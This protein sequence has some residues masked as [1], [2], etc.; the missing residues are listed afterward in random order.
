MLR[1]PRLSRAPLLFGIGLLSLSDA[2]GA[3]QV[4]PS[5]IEQL[6]RTLALEDGRTSGSG[7]LDRILRGP[8]KGLRRRAALAAGRIG[9]RE[10]LPALLEMLNDGEPELRQMAAFSLGLIGDSAGV[11]RL[12]AALADSDPR[13]RSR[14]AEALGRIGNSRAAAPIVEYIRRVTPLTPA[15]LVVRGDDPTN[16][17]DPWTEVRLGLLALPGL[18]DTRA[19]EAA[20]LQNAESKYDWWVSA[21]V[22]SRMEAPSLAPVLVRAARTGDVL[23]KICAARGLGALRNPVHLPLLSTLASDSDERVAVAAIRALA[24]TGEARASRDVVAALDSEREAGAL[25]QRA[26]GVAEILEEAHAGAGWRRR[27]KPAA[28]AKVTGFRRRGDE[29]KG[30]GGTREGGRRKSGKIGKAGKR[31]T[32]GGRQE[33]GKRKAGERGPE[34][35][36]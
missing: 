12:T 13:V 14:A 18:K 23:S 32:E 22:A 36:R 25:A 6:G 5:R 16:P 26:A 9:S 35:N 17:G 4:S 10:A 1:S 33:G 8:D 7:E 34:P 30:R 15:P 28:A 27:G 11:D 31:K 24:A 20:L 2:W 19:A 3:D 21:W 29:N